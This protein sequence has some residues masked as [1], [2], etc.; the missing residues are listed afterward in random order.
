MSEPYHTVD[1]ASLP[2]DDPRRHTFLS[3]RDGWY[4][5]G[6]W[7]ISHQHGEIVWIA[8][9]RVHEPRTWLLGMRQ[10]GLGEA[11][12]TE[13]LSETWY[14]L[15]D[16]SEDEI[17]RRIEQAVQMAEAL[18]AP[19]DCIPVLIRAEGR[20][21]GVIAEEQMTAAF[22]A[23]GV[24]LPAAR[25]ASRRRSRRWPPPAMERQFRGQEGWS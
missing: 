25:P 20:R 18:F 12:G 23:R 9:R 3:F 6:T 14:P 16:R 17:L 4:Y 13:E 21:A 15:D 19:A 5:L 2:P 8:C 11:P 10:R 22:E 1:P 24:S 7:S